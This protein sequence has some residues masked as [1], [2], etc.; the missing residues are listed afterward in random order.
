MER[1]VKELSEQS[2]VF[3]NMRDHLGR[4]FL[5]EAVEQQNTIFVECMLGIGCNPNS[6]EACGATPL[7]IA[8]L[9]HNKEICEMLINCGASVRGP[10]FVNVPSPLSMAEKMELEEICELMQ[11]ILSDEEDD[12]IAS[13]DTGFGKSVHNVVETTETQEI[14]RSSCGYITGVVGDIGTCKNNRSVMTRSSGYSWVG[15]IPG[16]MHTKG[17]LVEACFKEQGPGGLHFLGNKVMKRPKLIASAFKKKKFEEGN[18]LRIREA[19]RDGARSYG[20]AAVLEFTSSPFYPSLDEQTQC[21]RSTGNISS[22][23]LSKFKQFLECC[24]RTDKSF[25]CR[26]RMFLFYGPLMDLFDL[27]TQHCWGKAREISY[28]LQ[29]PMYAQLNF[30]NYYAETFVHVINILGK[31]PLAFRHLVENN[32]SVNMSGRRG[33]GIELDAFVESEIVQPLKLYV[34]GENFPTVQKFEPI[35]KTLQNLALPIHDQC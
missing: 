32:C 13:Y 16:D 34:S 29:L 35:S 18:L 31:W 9:L 30:R 7:T 15:V 14:N 22:I 6:K 3:G 28:I 27:S 26:S 21:R 19:A 12:I 5:H 11:P 4:T 33:G 8:V 10:L 25:K 24:I 23:L 20:L 17:H 2:D 1:L